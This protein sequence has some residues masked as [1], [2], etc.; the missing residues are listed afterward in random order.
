M[1]NV[2]NTAAEGGNFGV[3]L[4]FVRLLLG[5]QYLFSAMK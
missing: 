2:P 1:L 3:A 4:V 5:F